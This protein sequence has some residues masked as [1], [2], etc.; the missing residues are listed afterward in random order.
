MKEAIVC[1]STT[2]YL[3]YCFPFFCFLR[4]LNKD[5][6]TLFLALLV[7]NTNNFFFI[8]LLM[9]RNTATKNTA[10]KNTATK[11]TA[12]K[13]TATKSTASKSTANKSTTNKKSASSS[14]Q[15]K[16]Q[17][18]TS[19][20]SMMDTLISQLQLLM[21]LTDDFTKMTEPRNTA[22][23]VANKNAQGQEIQSYQNENDSDSDDIDSFVDDDEE[24][25]YN[26]KYDDLDY[27]PSEVSEVDRFFEMEYQK[28]QVNDEYDLRY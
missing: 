17:D 14:K 20:N 27:C 6:K 5:N 1:I 2:C 16:D 15:K 8:I 21:S 26:E 13:N 28:Q 18:D 4:F 12:T 9:P 3:C 19:S 25:P 23:P 24:D 22:Q 7:E 10:T 11:N